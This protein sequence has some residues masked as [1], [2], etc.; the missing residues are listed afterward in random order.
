[1]LFISWPIVCLEIMDQ[2]FKYAVMPDSHL[3]NK[4]DIFYENN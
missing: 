3:G 4:R 1:M 2:M